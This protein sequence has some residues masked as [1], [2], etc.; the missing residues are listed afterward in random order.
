MHAL[1][2]KDVGT[3]LC[4]LYD[5]HTWPN[6]VS[7]VYS[8]AKTG[9]LVCPPDHSYQLAPVCVCGGGGG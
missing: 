7:T 6:Y 4:V 9:P 1:L 8:I 5:K 2:D 3:D